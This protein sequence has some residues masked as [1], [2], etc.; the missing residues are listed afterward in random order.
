MPNKK[1]AIEWLELS[2]HHL[3]AAEILIKANHFTDVIGQ[4]LQQSIEKTI[5]AVFAYEGRRIC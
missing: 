4:E 3:E 1:Y 5:K 2:R